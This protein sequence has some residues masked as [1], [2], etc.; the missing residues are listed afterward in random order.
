MACKLNTVLNTKY[1][2]CLLMSV[3]AFA[4]YAQ[5][6]AVTSSGKVVL[7]FA[8]N[9]WKFKEVIA[10]SV[11]SD[12]IQ[13]AAAPDSTAGN[14]LPREA[15]IYRDSVSGFR[16]FLR[17]ELKLPSL[18]EQSEGYYEFRV[19]VNREGIVKEVTTTKRGPNGQTE[20]VIR[21][22]ITRMRFRH[23]NSVVPPLTEGII[24]ITVPA[25]Y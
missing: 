19:K 3:W 24:R 23:D 16:G 20:T 5:E 7:L 2:V 8:D 12:S 13:T 1:F 11:Q 4:S 9:T 22:T 18:P 25:G 10:D 21:N 6:E 15:K 17:P 14:A